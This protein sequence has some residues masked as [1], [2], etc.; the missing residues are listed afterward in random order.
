MN[1]P[2]TFKKPLK[3]AVKVPRELPPTFKAAFG[4]MLDD[5]K[6]KG[7]KAT[8]GKPLPPRMDWPE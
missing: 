6:A 8:A 1:P 2:L 7:S 3:N 5:E 4:K